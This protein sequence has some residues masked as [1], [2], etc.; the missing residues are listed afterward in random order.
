[1][2]EQTKQRLVTELRGYL[3][4][5]PET[6]E[7]SGPNDDSRDSREI[8]LYTL[9]TELAGLRNEIRLESRQVKRALDEFSGVFSTLEDNGK[10]LQSELNDR[11]DKQ[12]AVT[13][14][15]ERGLLLELIELRDRLA[16]AQALASSHQPG[17]LA[18]FFSPR[19]HALVQDMAEGL[20]ITLRRLDQA[21]ASYDVKP[22]KA[23]GQ[24]IDPHRMR[25]AAVRTQTEQADGLALEEVRRGY[26]RAG[27]VLRLAEVVA[28][29]TR[30]PS[31]N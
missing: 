15:A 24:V 4:G 22:I 21:L 31:S 1:M 17:A 7:H 18:R 26:Q 8:D 29:K 25:V 16:Q 3:D 2:D 23:V 9:F 27:E 11:R 12:A 19:Q 14:N 5:L 13:A 30:D 6:P 20:G 10:R 28:N